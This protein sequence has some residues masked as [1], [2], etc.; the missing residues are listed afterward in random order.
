QDW[1]AFQTLDIS[2]YIKTGETNTLEMPY[3]RSSLNRLE[4]IT[5]PSQGE[6]KDWRMAGTDALLPQQWE[7]YEVGQE[8]LHSGQGSIQRAGQPGIAAGGNCTAN[9]VPRTTNE[10]VNRATLSEKSH[11]VSNHTPVRGSYG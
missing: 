8:S 2:L 4:L 9:L 6:L 1:F 7:S 3:S 11:P 10:S 5:Y